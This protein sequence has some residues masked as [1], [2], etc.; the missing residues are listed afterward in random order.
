MKGLWIEGGNF[1][2]SPKSVAVFCIFAGSIILYCEESLAW[3][4]ACSGSLTSGQ[5]IR[6]LSGL[7][8]GYALCTSFMLW[9]Y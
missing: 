2:V 8:Q 6:A 9:E 1:D 7:P 3:F 4:I 5:L